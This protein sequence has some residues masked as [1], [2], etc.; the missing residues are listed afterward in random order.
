M[1]KSEIW[2]RLAKKYLTDSEFY[3]SKKRPRLKWNILKL[4]IV[5]EIERELK[6]AGE[7][8]PPILLDYESKFITVYRRSHVA[9]SMEVSHASTIVKDDGFYIYVNPGVFLIQKRTFLAHELGHTFFF[10][11]RLLPPKPLVKLNGVQFIRSW[12]LEGL[13]FLFGR[14]I[15]IPTFLLVHYVPENPTL[16][17]FFHACKTFLVTKQVMAKR[18]Y[19][20][21]VSAGGKNYWMDSVLILYPPN[22]IMS[23]FKARVFPPPRGPNEVY[24]GKGF[25][26][27]VSVS[28]L[29]TKIESNLF[30]IFKNPNKVVVLER[31]VDWRK[32]KLTL[33]GYFSSRHPQNQ[34]LYLLIYYM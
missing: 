31:C 8:A 33:E 9:E 25:P 2:S 13:S 14:E 5:R 7:V 16:A 20:N 11:C 28:E 29:W 17:A 21:P 6:E 18:L 3:M 19:W 34:F 12:D 30:L 27:A 32:K 15:L 10:D 26:A 23:G 4:A 1:S 24:K 22:K